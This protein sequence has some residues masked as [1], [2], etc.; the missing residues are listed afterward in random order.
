[1][2]IILFKITAFLAVLFTGLGGGLLALRVGSMRNS[3]KIFSLGNAFAGGIFLGAGLLHMFPDARDSFKTILGSYDFPW[4]S[5]ICACGFL[6]ILFIE[7]VATRGHDDLVQVGE[8]TSHGRF[9]PYILAVVLSIH[10]LIAGIALG[11]EDIIAKA[12]IILLAIVA[13][14]GSAVFALSVNL[15]KEGVN[16]KQLGKIITLFS[17]MTPAGI[18]LGVLLTAFLKGKAEVMVEGVFDALAAGTFLY[19]AF[20]DIIEEE[21]SVAIDRGKKFILLTFGLG[22]MAVLAVFL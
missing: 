6:L 21:F 12:F 14:K 11:T 22:V 3:Q 9:T 17:F 1:M 15:T 16:G 8:A 20:I 13:H 4:V 5:L 18:I 2:N 7:K 19:V 10:S